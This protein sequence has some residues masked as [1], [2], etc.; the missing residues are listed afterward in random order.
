M[1]HC[2]PRHVCSA[3]MVAIG[4]CGLLAGRGA[5]KP[6]IS[7][8]VVGFKT[9]TIAASELGLLSDRE[10]V[11]AVI[12]MSNCGA[13]PVIFRADEDMPCYRTIRQ[14]GAIWKESACVFECG[15]VVR[16]RSLGPGQSLTFN[17]A[18][19]RDRP[20]RISVPYRS[21]NLRTQ[22]RRFLPTWLVQRVS[23]LSPV[24]AVATPMITIGRKE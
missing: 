11:C 14:E 15:L 18:V 21:S 23:W 9:N 13:R 1:R 10:S 19:E 2:T 3:I 5:P 6:G 22:V 24:S 17:A 20:C 4:L 7:L 16:D 8:A 12:R